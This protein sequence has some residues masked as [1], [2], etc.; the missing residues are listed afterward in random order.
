MPDILVLNDFCTQV[1][2]VLAS[3]IV[4]EEPSVK[5]LNEALSLDIL[6]KTGASMEKLRRLRLTKELRFFDFYIGW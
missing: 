6:A 5:L 4:N 1:Q 2:S 3:F